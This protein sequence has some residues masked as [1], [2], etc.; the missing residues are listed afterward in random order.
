MRAQKILTL[1]PERVGG[2]YLVVVMPQ[3]PLPLGKIGPA[4]SR[5]FGQKMPNYPLKTG[6]LRFLS[7]NEGPKNSNSATRASWRAL[8][9][10]CDAPTPSTFGENRARQLEIVRSENAQ[11]P[12]KNGLFAVFKRK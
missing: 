8:F 6:F 2:P 4:N 1:Q 9:G 10:G 12:P 3:P 7:E 5:L 11:L